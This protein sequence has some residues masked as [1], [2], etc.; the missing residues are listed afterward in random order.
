MPY[1]VHPIR[2]LIVANPILAIAEIR[3]V[4]IACGMCKSDVAKH[5]GCTHGTF[6]RWLNMLG[7][8]E[9][10]DL[11][12]EQA[13]REGWSHNRRGGR[14]KGSTVRNGARRRNTRVKSS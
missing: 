7:L 10:V 3:T 5:F 12:S 14:P 9:E 6:L 11:L 2:A 13:K 8:E 1:V 4:L